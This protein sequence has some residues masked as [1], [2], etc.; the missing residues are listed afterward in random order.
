MHV[1][2]FLLF[3]IGITDMQTRE[4]NMHKSANLQIIQSFCANGLTGPCK[5]CFNTELRGMNNLYLFFCIFN[6]VGEPKN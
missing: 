1:F 2:V 4:R 3:T 5:N 6:V